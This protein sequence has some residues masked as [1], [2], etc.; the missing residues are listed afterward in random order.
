MLALLF[1]FYPEENG[2]EEGGGGSAEREPYLQQRGK[3][4]NPGDK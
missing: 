3:G 2:D 1:L 4:E